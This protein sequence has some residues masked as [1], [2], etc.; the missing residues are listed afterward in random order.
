MTKT[1][2]IPPTISKL[3]KYVLDFSKRK[4]PGVPVKAVN[5]SLQFQILAS[6]NRLLAPGNRKNCESVCQKFGKEFEVWAKRKKP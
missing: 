4:S 6:V 1:F 2:E 3:S 5:F